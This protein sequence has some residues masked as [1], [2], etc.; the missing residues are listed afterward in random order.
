[1]EGETES[2]LRAHA[3]YNTAGAYGIRIIQTDLEGNPI[4]PLPCSNVPIPWCCGYLNR[5]SI[6]LIPHY[7]CP[8]RAFTVGFCPP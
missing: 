2:K 4:P 6:I 5:P 8:R 7:S 1:M 3:S